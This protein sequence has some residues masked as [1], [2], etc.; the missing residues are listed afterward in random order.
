MPGWSDPVIQNRV[1]W[2]D[3]DIVVSVPAK[4]GTTWT[5]NIVHHLDSG[6]MVRKG[7]V[8]AANDDGVTVEISADIARIGR[9]ILNDD[10]AY[11]WFYRGGALPRAANR[12]SASSRAGR[13]ATRT[14]ASRRKKLARHT[15]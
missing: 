10:A 3:G 7:K 9:K 6:A 11:E 2:R 13:A 14:S 4:S 12:R 1:R 15:A 8:G 5:M